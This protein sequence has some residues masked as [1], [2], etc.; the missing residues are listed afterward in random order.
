[1][2]GGSESIPAVPHQDRLKYN[3]QFN[4]NDRL[5]TGF[6]EGNHAKTIFTM[7]SKLP[8][9]VLKQVWTLSDQD[10]DGKLSREEF[11]LSQ[12]LIACAK[13]GAQLP[14]TVP[15]H[16]VINKAAAAPIVHRKSLE[17]ERRENFQKGQQ[18]L[19]AKR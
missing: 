8:P 6:I 18:A 2:G 17:D 4:A 5:K 9:N 3:Q 11:I 16:L 19:L 13:R 14:E 10:Q 15:P 1:M 7:E 12:H